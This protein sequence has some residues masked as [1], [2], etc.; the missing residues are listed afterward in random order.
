MF[1]ASGDSLG[2]YS[3]DDLE[4]GEYKLL[5]R[6]RGF[7][8]DTTLSS[9][10]V[11]EGSVVRCGVVILDAAP[12]DTAAVDGLQE[13]QRALDD[14]ASARFARGEARLRALFDSRSLPYSA[15]ERAATLLAWCALAQGGDAKERLARQSF[16]LGLLV[17]PWIEP[18][19]EASPRVTTIL[20]MVR[21]EMF[22]DQ[23][24]PEGIFKP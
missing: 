18:G 14:Y 11:G 16:R 5:F 17:N 10:M 9:V 21:G 8:P 6:A 3:C 20:E 12:H 13:L 19:A 7:Y 24:P 23:G 4:P 15:I 2:R 22:G 1:D